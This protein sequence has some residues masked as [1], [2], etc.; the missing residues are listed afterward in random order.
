MREICKEYSKINSKINSKNNSVPEGGYNLLP[1]KT[2]VSNCRFAS[3][4]NQEG[5]KQHD[6][7]EA[8]K[9]ANKEDED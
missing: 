8:Q 5:V 4:S 9:E 7:I 1:P 3:E 2:R 6:I